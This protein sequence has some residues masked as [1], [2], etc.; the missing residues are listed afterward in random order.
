MGDTRRDGEEGGVGKRPIAEIVEGG[1]ADDRGAAGVGVGLVSAR[2][3]VWQ[4]A[5]PWGEA[6]DLA[7]EKVLAKG[8]PAKDGEPAGPCMCAG[9]PASNERPVGPTDVRSREKEGPTGACW[10]VG[11]LVAPVRGGG[12]ELDEPGIDS[13]MSDTHGD[14]TFVGPQSNSKI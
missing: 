10:V 2:E 6:G 1:P 12:G 13:D 5:G 4:P 14:T 9:E 7:C 11:K 8:G 3:P